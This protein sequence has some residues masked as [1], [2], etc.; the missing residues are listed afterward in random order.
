LLA[1]RELNLP[2]IGMTLDYGH[3]LYSGEQ[4]GCTVALVNKH[5]KLIGLHLNDA[6]GHRDD[7]MM[8]GSVNT[9]RTIELLLQMER[10]GYDGV[11][12]FD[13]FPDLTALDPIAETETNIA[14]V[15]AMMSVVREL[16]ANPQLYP[17]QVR[18]DAIKTQRIVQRTLFGAHYPD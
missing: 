16:D 12:Y 15:K 10:D 1:I 2:N 17:A 6:Y 18:Q 11:Y 13:T 7:G 8:V 3:V 14:T 4:P 5:S 9:L